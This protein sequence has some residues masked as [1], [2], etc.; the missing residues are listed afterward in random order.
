M[1]ANQFFEKILS[2]FKPEK[3]MVVAKDHEH[4]NILN[5]GAQED[6]TEAYRRL[7]ANILYLPLESKCRKIAITSATAGEGKTTVATNLAI[8]LAQTLVSSKVLLIDTDM[9]KAGIELMMSS[10]TQS[11]GL[12][13]FLMG[14]DEEPNIVA[15]SVD[16]LYM[17]YAGQYP[18]NPTR[19]ISSE[20]MSALFRHC[21]ENFDYII[22]DTPALDAGSEAILLKKHVNGYVFVAKS[23]NSDVDSLGKAMDSLRSLG[24]TILGMVLMG[25][26]TKKNKNKNLSFRK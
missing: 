23:K 22:L 5:F 25:E 13:E 10:E 2:M 17:L 8:T 4:Y 19:L 11:K 15:S 26:E 24:A 3:K 12:S 20:R 21:E 7:Y 16:G 14:E 9:R 1:R 18:E 6:V